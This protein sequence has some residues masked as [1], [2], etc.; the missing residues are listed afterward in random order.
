MQIL[1][2]GDRGSLVS[3]LQKGL[4]RAGWGPLAADGIFGPATE[5]AVKK[6][7]RAMGLV[8]DGIA[9]PR[10]WRALSPWLLGYAVHTV[11]RGDTL[12][13]IAGRYDASLLA[14]EAANPGLDPFDLRPGQK[15]TVPYSFPV[16]PTDIPW[17]SALVD[18]C[19][20]GLRARYPFLISGELGRSVMGRPIWRLTLG[21]GRRRVLYNATHHAN[22][23]ITTPLLLQFAEELLW[24]YVSGGNVFGYPAEELWALTEIT[25]VPAVNP[26]GM[27][28]VTGALE[29]EFLHQAEILAANYPQI[30][31][32]AGWKANIRG[33]D[34]N[35]QYPA[36]WEEARRIKFSQGYTLPGPRD[37]VGPEALSAPESLAMYR[38]T[39]KTDP[40][41]VLAWHT[42]GEVIYW[43]YLDF[44]PEGSRDLAQRL[45]AASGY[46]WEET[47]YASGYGG[48]KDWFIQ[49][50]NRPGYT[51]EAG[52][53]ENPLPLSQFD[54]IRRAGQGILTLAALG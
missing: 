48:Y 49:D 28:L 51:I 33:V 52:R 13:R 41:L 42:Q 34:L 38:Y 32:P 35:L 1:K 5:S 11:A 29:G 26:D 21:E 46:A 39:R 47:P 37:Y 22:E 23:W 44:E 40:A 27:D 12:W 50:Y 24:A 14:L 4:A 17:S 16:V 54:A 30:P 25:L 19:V 10:T 15:L 8:P 36:G 9:G 43:K 6:F 31:F 53:G 2:S 7:Q 45:S 18:C 20:R 3:L